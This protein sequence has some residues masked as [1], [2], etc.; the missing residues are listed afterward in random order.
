MP[1]TTSNLEFATTQTRTISCRVDRY[2]QL[3][4]RLLPG[5][6]PSGYLVAAQVDWGEREAGRATITR[7]NAL[8]YEFQW[9]KNIGYN[10]IDHVDIVR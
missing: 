1:F 3:A 8:G 2:A 5:A 10:L 4:P 9:I 7:S 6:D